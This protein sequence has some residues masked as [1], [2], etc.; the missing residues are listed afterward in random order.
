[1]ANT[2]PL[3]IV[4][5]VI[6]I[7]IAMMIWHYV[8]AGQI[9]EHWAK[10]NGYEILSSEHRWLRRGPFFWWTG[11]GQE[12]Y[13]VTVRTPDGKLRRGWIRCGSYFWGVLSD[14]AEVRWDE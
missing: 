11:R 6:I 12:V 10:D 4:V 13:Y 7:A 1:M 5:A 3:P 8:R 9:L 14:S 2:T